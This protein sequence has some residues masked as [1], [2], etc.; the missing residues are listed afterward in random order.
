[1]NSIQLSRT[2]TLIGYFGLLGFIPLWYLV[3]Q[4]IEAKFVSMTLLIQAGPLLFPLRG[5]LHGRVYTH[6]WA[7]YLALFYFIIGIWYAGDSSTRLFGIIFSL[8]SVLFFIG[9]MLYTRFQGQA[10]NAQR[11]AAEDARQTQD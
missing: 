3:L 9:S 6:A 5:I 1:M 11:Q 8:L 10:E 7:M 4:P 2:L